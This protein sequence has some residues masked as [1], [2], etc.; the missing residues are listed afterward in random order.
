SPDGKTLATVAGEGAP[1][2]WDVATGKLRGRL[3]AGLTAFAPD[4][5]AVV[6]TAAGGVV[7]FWDPAT[8]EEKDSFKIGHK[9]PIT[10]L[11]VSPDGKTLATAASTQT[12]DPGPLPIA[13][14]SG[15]VKL[16][17][18]AGKERATI[19]VP[20]GRVSQ[21]AF[22]PD[23]KALLVISGS[24]LNPSEG[25]LCDPAGN[26]IAVLKGLGGDQV[27]A[28]Y[29]PDGKALAVGAVNQTSR[30]DPG[31]ITLWDVTTG[32]Q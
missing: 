5:K 11:A 1:H 4:G 26:P 3:P 10:A 15:E 28:V 9:A 7:K 23:G 8:F 22:S 17:D 31:V 21:L 18:V 12:N 19:P 24:F 6:S 27:S 2:F 13:R 20:T 25:L 16:W 32:R 14:E 29:T 30:D